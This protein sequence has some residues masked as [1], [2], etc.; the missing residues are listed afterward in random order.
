MKK[1]TFAYIQISEA[2]KKSK[3]QI[4]LKNI[5]RF[6]MIISSNTFDTT[7][8][9]LQFY[10]LTYFFSNYKFIHGFRSKW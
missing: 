4:S 2:L 3:Y 10:Q 1:K 5:S 6:T 7:A 8:S 9:I